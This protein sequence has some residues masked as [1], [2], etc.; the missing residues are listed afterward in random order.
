MAETFRELG[1]GEG[2][3]SVLDR[4]GYTRPTAV[5][6]AAIPVLRRGANAVIHAAPGAGATIA[7]GVALVERLRETDQ[8][9][10][11]LQALVVTPTE[12]RAV[13]VALEL[14]QLGR[15]DGLGAGVLAPGW[16][17][18]A[19]I[20]VVPVQRVLELLQSSTLKLDD[21]KT[22]VLH[23]VSAM[24]ALDQ[25]EQIELLL[26]TVPREAQR[27]L[28]ASEL[29]TAVEKLAE[30]HVR[31]ALHVPARPALRD[32]VPLTDAAVTIEYQV[33]RGAPA[34]QAIAE[35][36]A[37]AGASAVVFC[38]RKLDSDR[39]QEELALRGL[40]AKTRLYGEALQ[41]GESPIGL[42]A[43]LDAETLSSTFQRAGPLVLEAGQLTHLHNAARQA[44]V[45]LQAATPRGSERVGLD[46]FRQTLRRALQEEDIEAQLLVIEPLLSEFSAEEIA[47]AASALLRRRAPA[48]E[49]PAR[50]GPAPGAPAPAFVKLFLSVGQ[51]DAVAAREIVG[52]ITGEASVAGEQVGRVEIRDTFSIVE[53]A[54][55]IA[56][57][58][59]R[60]LNGTSLKGRSLRVDYDRKPSPTR[61][62][63]PAR[64][65]H[66]RQ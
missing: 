40:S 48:P 30:A 3:L 33:L 28:V 54:A 11:G 62:T 23:D 64:R 29:N 35:A 60:A 17:G 16:Q 34:R 55:D 22:L 26:Q 53:V 8:S 14:G 61:R 57:R 19:G 25:H 45:R 47:A 58:V 27:V 43:P 37:K 51:R 2:L 52:A 1:I 65:T 12:E 39:V 5:Q 9:D 21:M 18:A 38:R 41:A 20:T 63:L 13:A 7:Y 36:V 15:P 24:L 10:Q 31:K 50:A 59:I 66:P 56:E 4:L 6:R 42:G 44:R 32:E 46:R 49:E